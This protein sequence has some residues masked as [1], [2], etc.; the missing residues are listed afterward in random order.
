M[1]KNDHLK[2]ALAQVSPHWLDKEKSIYKAISYIKEAAKKKAKLVIFGETFLPG[3]PFWLNLTNGSEF[4]SKVQK[5]IYSY[6]SNQALNIEKGDL[7]EIQNLCKTLSIHLIIG[8]VEKAMD[9]GG[10]SLYCT[11]LVID[12]NGQIL[13]RHRKLVPTYE[14]RLVWAQGDGHGLKVF[15]IGKFQMGALNCWENWMPLCRS[16][17]YAMGEDLHIALW[18]GNHRNTEDI[19]QFIAKESRSYVVSV[20]ATLNKSD[21]N[22]KIPHSNQI[23]ENAPDIVAN[24]G[25]C[26]CGPD[27]E[28]VL[29]PQIQTEELF[30][31]DLDHGKIR[32]ERQNFDPSGHYSRPD[33]FELSV[34][35]KR[36]SIIKLNK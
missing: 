2:I 15:P 33:V 7:I 23:K 25:S 18:P 10:H 21:I 30:I 6:Y 36:Q 17:L 27:G 32:Q 35:T 31:V 12:E 9:R 1:D 34:N 28:W 8:A 22:D 14:E 29:K 16:S 3:Y 20:S 19:T 13:N 4:N 5:E 26:V 24:G 11:L